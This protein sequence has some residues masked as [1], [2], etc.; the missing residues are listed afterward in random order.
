[1]ETTKHLYHKK[2][3]YIPLRAELHDQIIEKIL[4]GT[5]G[6]EVEPTATLIGGGSGSGK[7]SVIAKLLTQEHDSEFDNGIIVIDCD[8]IKLE[9]PEYNQMINSEDE[10]TIEAAASFVHDESSDIADK[11]LQICIFSRRS[12]IYDGTMKN[13][14]KYDA[15]IKQLKQYGYLVLAYVVDVPFEI[16]LERIQIRAEVEKRHVDTIVAFE[17][18]VYFSAT[19]LRLKHSFDEFTLFDN[20]HDEVKVIAFKDEGGSEFIENQQRYKEF[21]SKAKMSN[22]MHQNKD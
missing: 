12:F 6:N 14:V 18:H 15:I 20:T 10:M 22:V 16:A 3:S 4:K 7:S 21:V 5:R 11:L 8:K 9:L 1:M 2:D 17:S 19:F 13:F